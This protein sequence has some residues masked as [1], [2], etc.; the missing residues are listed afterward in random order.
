VASLQLGAVIG[1]ASESEIET[2]G[3]YGRS[4]GLAFQIVDDCLD[5]ESTPEQMG[6]MTR[7]DENHG[8]LTYPNL[9]GLAESKQLADE[10][11]SDAIQSVSVFESQGRSLVELA[12][13][14]AER[15]S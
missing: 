13:F 10:L 2:L 12:K 6:K 14:V 11:I 8:K 15:R 1:G 5:I 9:L 7:K 4:I 3:S